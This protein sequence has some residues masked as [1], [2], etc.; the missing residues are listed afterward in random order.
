VF[1]T[2]TWYLTVA[3]PAS[4]AT[5]PLVTV[6]VLGTSVDVTATLLD[7]LGPKV[8]LG[9]M[10]AWPTTLTVSVTVV[11]SGCADAVKLHVAVVAP[12]AGISIAPQVL[13]LMVWLLL[14][15][16]QARPLNPATVKMLPKALSQI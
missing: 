11:S 14:P 5:N 1:F 4:V 2:S 13:L 10:S 16:G 8:L 12:V 7:V 9:L 15:A 6:A 3:Q